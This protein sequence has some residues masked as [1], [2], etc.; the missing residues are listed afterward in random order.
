MLTLE[1][2]KRIYNKAPADRL[3]KYYQPLCTALTAAGIDTPLREAAFLAQI[4]HESDELRYM[5]EVW[6]PTPQ[7]LRYDPPTKLAAKLGNMEPGDG[8]RFRGAGPL[9]ITGRENFRRAGKALGLD[10]ESHPEQAFTPAVGFKLAAWFWDTH[11]LNKFA[12]AQ[13]F[14]AITLRINGGY[15]GKE[16]RDRRYVIARHVLGCP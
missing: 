7:Q 11:G 3:Q 6:G 15:I 16:D 12:D 13:D 8:Y 10:L 4:G 2:L 9:Q 14:D 1:Q 5:A